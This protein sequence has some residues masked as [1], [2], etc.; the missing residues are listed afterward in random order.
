MEALK[1]ECAVL[2][3]ELESLRHVTISSPRKPSTNE[4]ESFDPVDWS[5]KL[6]EISADH[7]SVV[8]QTLFALTIDDRNLIHSVKGMTRRFGSVKSYSKHL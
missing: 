1:E 4:G 3:R 6:E 8:F 2:R 5:K 7:L